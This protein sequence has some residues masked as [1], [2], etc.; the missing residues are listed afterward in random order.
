MINFLYFTCY[1]SNHTGCDKRNEILQRYKNKAYRLHLP[2]ALPLPMYCHPQVTKG[3]TG[4]LFHT[5]HLA[6]TTICKHV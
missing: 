1:L 5:L 3:D 4:M 2:Q 6:H